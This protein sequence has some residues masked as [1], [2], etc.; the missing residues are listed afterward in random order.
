MSGRVWTA[1][2]VRV[3]SGA[4]HHASDQAAGR[5]GQAERASTRTHAH[6][7]TCKQFAH[8]CRRLL[9]C[10]V[11]ACNVGASP[12]GKC[13][14]MATAKPRIT[15]TLEPDVYETIKG[16][17][18]AQGCTMSGLVSGFLA[19]VNPV[20]QRVLRAVKKAQSINVESK[21]SMVANLEQAEAQMTEM[22]GP[23][24]AL[25]DT[26]SE[27][28]P[29]HSNTGVTHTNTS[30]SDNRKKPRKTRP[31]EVQTDLFV[32]KDQ[33]PK[34][35]KTQKHKNPKAPANGA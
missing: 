32:E 29:P 33:K 15:V 5:G 4:K 17:S 27:G 2:R 30:G 35:P 24:L 9:Q 12:S 1:G 26:V 20:Q 14:T 34:N 23:L 11:C 22:L 7:H 21:A 13:I 28:Q 18:E 6:A 31:R 3:P 25:L 19:M 16:L 8:T 10:S